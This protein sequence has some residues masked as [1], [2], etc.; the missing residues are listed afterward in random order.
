MWCGLLRLLINFSW[1]SLFLSNS[2]CWSFL[3]LGRWCYVCFGLYFLLLLFRLGTLR[4]LLLRNRSFLFSSCQENIPSLYFFTDCF[5][6]SI[7]KM[8]KQLLGTLLIYLLPND[9]SPSSSLSTFRTWTLNWLLNQWFSYFILNRII[10]V[11]QYVVQIYRNFV[12]NLLC[13]RLDNL[14]LQLLVYS[15]WVNIIQ[16]S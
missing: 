10:L 16:N 15:N 4:P 2:C 6:C 9:K 14:L 3:N 1:F 8:L 13:F 5:L 7:V 12:M 11:A